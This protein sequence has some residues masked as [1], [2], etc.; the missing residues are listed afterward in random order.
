[1]TPADVKSQRKQM[2]IAWR[3][4]KLE[5]APPFLPANFPQDGI[6]AKLS[7]ARDGRRAREK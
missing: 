5:Q 6:A 1:M 7:A 2:Q 4:A 3:A